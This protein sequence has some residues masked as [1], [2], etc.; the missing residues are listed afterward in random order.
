MH[1]FLETKRLVLRRF[2]EADV[3]DL[4]LLDSDPEVMRFLTGEPTPRAE[5]EGDVLPR[6]LRDY[7]RGPAGRWAAIERST[8]EF[9]G[10]LA[11]QPPEDGNVAEV[12]LGYRLK[13]PVWGRGYATEGARALIRKG[14]TEL[15][16]QRV[17]AQTMAV[18]TASRRVL[19][20]AGLTYVRTFHPHFDDPLPGTEHGEVEY[21][22]RRARWAG[23]D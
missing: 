13:A 8:G 14:F 10:W 18:N 3:D 6:I 23:H 9:V 4:V 17:W 19:E 1:V 12:E 7:G 2:T 20:K 22:L 15:G 16:V 5:I 21:E 11:L